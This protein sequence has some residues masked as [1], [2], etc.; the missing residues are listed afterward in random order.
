MT[1]GDG[2]NERPSLALSTYHGENHRR[3]TERSAY[4]DDIR[5]VLSRAHSHFNIAAACENPSLAALQA[6][7][8]AV[9]SLICAHCA[10][11]ASSC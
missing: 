9:R 4:R 6:L 3:W 1:R 10:R 5:Y 2:R 7:A 11:A 8:N